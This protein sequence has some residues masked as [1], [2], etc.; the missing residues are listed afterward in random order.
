MRQSIIPASRIRRLS[1]FSAISTRESSRGVS[2]F[3]TSFFKYEI[4]ICE[5]SL[6]Q[7]RVIRMISITVANLLPGI[8]NKIFSLF[9]KSARLPMV[10]LISF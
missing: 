7:T 10:F 6:R 2:D 4:I 8:P 1:G 9:K 3:E 5:K